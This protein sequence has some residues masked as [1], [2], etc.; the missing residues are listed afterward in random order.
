MFSPGLFYVELL[1]MNPAVPISSGQPVGAF[2]GSGPTPRFAPGVLSPS[3]EGRSRLKIVYIRSPRHYWPILN[4]SD[5]FLVPLAYPTLAGYIRQHMPDVQQEIL[6]CCVAQMGYA[7]LRRWLIAHQPDVVCIGE[8]VVYAHEALR[9][10]Q[11]AREVLPN[12]VL[13]AGGQFFTHMTEY[14]FQ[15][16]PGLN[17]IVKYEGEAT[18]LDLLQTLRRG[19]DP[20]QVAGIA[21]HHDGRTVETIPRPLIEDMDTL[22]FPAYDLAGIERYAPFGKLWPRAVTVQRSRGCIDECKFCSWWVQ[23]GELRWNGEKWQA[24][25]K[26]R[27]KSPQRMVEEIA[28]LYET[29]N[30]RYLFWV[31]ATWNMDDAWL[32]EFCDE[33]IRRQYQL[34]WWAFFRVDRVQEQH[35]N[36]TL[37]KMVDAGLRHVLVGVERSE[38]QDVESLAKHRYTRERTK[39]AFAILARDYPEVFRQGTFITGLP[40]DD[41]QSIK[42]LVD[43]ALECNLDFAAFH[44]LTPF[45]GTPLYEETIRDPKMEEFD[46][47]RFDMFYPVMRTNHLSREQVAEYTTW[48]QQNFV[49]K[50]PARFFSR[51][52]SPYPVRRRLHWWFLFAISRVLAQ[53][54]I[55][56]A[57]GRKQFQGF[58]GVN[59]LWKPQWYET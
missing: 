26:V 47:S 35:K 29:Y 59:S 20:S 21:Y 8:K 44:P 5:N 55:L 53:D 12:A 50:N 6:D 48:C 56:S 14:S 23:E 9:T 30:V 40:E 41:E 3:L 54:L 45:P 22:P 15:A 46:F 10:F 57:A 11:L 49:G 42:G 34:G 51:L 13:I 31:D 18:F 7:S 43:Y 33:V 1:L 58:A 27:S 16:V 32:N 39:E 19:G 2:S 28:W 36:G 25:K 17:F 38:T 52:A 4:E 37:R 24:R